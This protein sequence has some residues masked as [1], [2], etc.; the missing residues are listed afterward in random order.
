MTEDPRVRDAL[1]H[2]SRARV[3]DPDALWSRIQAGAE[4]RPPRR[5][6]PWAVAA[7]A[8]LAVVGGTVTGVVWQYR[9]PASWAVWR[10]AGTPAVDGVP[11]REAGTLRTGDWLETGPDAR[12]H[13]EVGGIGTA[14]VGPGSRVRLERDGFAARR[15]LL[16][17]GSLSAVITAPP[18]LFF[19]R[20]PATLATD[21]GCAYT[22]AVDDAGT[23]RLHVTAG[24]VELSEGDARSIVPAGMVAVVET[25][26]RPGTPYAE[27][28]PDSARAALARL[29][30]GQGSEADLSLVLAAV[31]R[32]TDHV[33]YRQRGG[34]T[35]W[36]LVQRLAGAQQ[37]RVIRRLAELSPP[38]DG[39]TMEGIAA[40]ERPMLE[41]WRRD[42]NPMWSE[43][44]APWYAR[45]GRRAWTWAMR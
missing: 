43:E 19:V 7:A 18:R 41:R 31:A 20:T 27:D 16:E 2:L 17:R 21:L 3:R 8:V 40:L 6:A 34:I 32:T 12:A 23:S 15:L 26:R 28:F 10:L 14:Q 42:L 22:L 30:E 5:I 11:L 45:I 44:A 37:Q 38:P 33:T 9:A 35:L 4:R 13:L 24:W 25:G 39:V 29:D 36:H 1:A